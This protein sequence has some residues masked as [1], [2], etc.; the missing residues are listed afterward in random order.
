VY[1]DVPEGWY[2]PIQRSWTKPGLM[3]GV[4]FGFAVMNFTWTAALTLGG[5]KLW[6]LPVGLLLHAIAVA[7]TKMDPYFFLGWQN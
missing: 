5:Q 4:P 1:D 7:A 2:V 6:V 3:G